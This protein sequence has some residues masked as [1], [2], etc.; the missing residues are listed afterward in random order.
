MHC[1]WPN[2]SSV[3]QKCY[4]PYHA[5]MSCPS[6]TTQ[7]QYNQQ[8]NSIVEFSEDMIIYYNDSYSLFTCYA[9][10]HNHY[11]VFVIVEMPNKLYSTLLKTC[12]WIISS[13]L[14]KYRNILTGYDSEAPDCP[15]DFGIARLY[16]V[17]SHSLG[18]CLLDCVYGVQSN[19]F[20][21]IIFHIMYCYSTPL[22]PFS[23]KRLDYFLLLRSP[24]LR[25]TRW[26]E[27]G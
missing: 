3:W 24:S 18:L 17:H 13:K 11:H 19:M 2:T 20:M 16:S 4:A 9:A 5:V 8:N 23:D 27:I 1:D 6:T 10:P 25:N 7:K 21:F 22:C 14:F 12:I 15:C 26:A